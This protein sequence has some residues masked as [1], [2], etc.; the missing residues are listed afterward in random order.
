MA[1]IGSHSFPVIRWIIKEGRLGRFDGDLT[2][3]DA[4]LLCLSGHRRL[5]RPSGD[6]IGNAQL[7]WPQLKRNDPCQLVS[8]GPGMRASSQ[9]AP[10][11]DIA[12]GSDRGPRVDIANHQGMALT[13]EMISGSESSPMDSQV[14][15]F[16]HGLGVI[17]CVAGCCHRPLACRTTECSG[18]NLRF[19]AGGDD[20][21]DCVTFA[22]EGLHQFGELSTTHGPVPQIEV[23]RSNRQR[24]QLA[25]QP[26]MPVTVFV[27]RQDQDSSG[28]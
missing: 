27:R 25:W 11:V 23:D 13:V 16:L 21:L 15:P 4:S 3:L 28:L 2:I 8:G 1:S 12:L 17:G 6:T 9:A 20:L 10:D 18:C 26:L 7:Q 24:L 5:F 14:P 19:G 22:F